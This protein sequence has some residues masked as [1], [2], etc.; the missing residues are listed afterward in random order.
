MAQPEL[1]IHILATGEIRL[2][3][4]EATIDDV[5]GALDAAKLDGATVRYRR[6]EPSA[7]APSE[8]E[9][10][11]Q[12]ITAR[13][14]RIALSPSPDS[15]DAIVAEPAAENTSKVIEF[16]GI[17]LLF[18][19]L[20]KQAAGN[21]GVTLLRPDQVLYSLAAPA[22]GTINPQMEAG[23]KAMVPADQKRNIAA[24]SAAGALS[25]GDP[26]KPPAVVDIARQVPFF[27]LLIGLAYIGHAVWLF[28]GIE[29]MMPAGCE[30]ADLLLVDSHA[31]AS[32][33]S[34]WTTDAGAIMRNPNIL[35]WDRARNRMGALRTAGEVPGR[36]EF[37][38]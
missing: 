27:G 19:K 4:Q 34:S 23:V 30:D 29:T 31:V 1:N 17:E 12:M 36:I 25:A 26:G 20:R 14:L 7:E 3:G 9:Q 11:I 32:L 33:P 2:D 21:R 13:R 6:D 35:V 15:E 38:A 24:I 8:A 16:P 10:I 18:A 22:P 37:P 5:A 28:E